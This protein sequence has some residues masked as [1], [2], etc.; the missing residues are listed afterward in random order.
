MG[1]GVPSYRR[2]AGIQ[3]GQVGKNL[4]SR[5]RG[6]DDRG[7]AMLN[8]DFS[9]SRGDRKLMNHSFDCV[10]NSKLCRGSSYKR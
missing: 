7:P 4:D 8:L 9:F 2:T 5:L 6:N 1:L 3:P 10:K